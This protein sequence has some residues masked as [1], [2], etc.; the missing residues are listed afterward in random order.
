MTEWPSSLIITISRHTIIIII[1][2]SAVS[3]VI[4]GERNNTNLEIFKIISV[5]RMCSSMIILQGVLRRKHVLKESLS[6]NWIG[7]SISLAPYISLKDTYSALNM[8][9]LEI[10]VPLPPFDQFHDSSP[11]ACDHWSCVI[12]YHTPSPLS[13]HEI[14]EQPLRYIRNPGPVETTGSDNPLPGRVAMLI[15]LGFIDSD[16]LENFAI[17]IS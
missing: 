1:P 16:N 13:D 7:P 8:H 10:Q 17:H 12:I 11:L 3:R 6:L 15:D 2:W 4:T 14:L 5:S 9:I